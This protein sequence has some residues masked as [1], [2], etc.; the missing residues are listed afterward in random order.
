VPLDLP[1]PT[2]APNLD[3]LEK[4]ASD[5]VKIGVDGVM[6]YD[7]HLGIWGGGLDVAC[8]R[9]QEVLGL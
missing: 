8:S 1:P 9:L 3:N 7:A 4:W 6:L 2:S 5:V